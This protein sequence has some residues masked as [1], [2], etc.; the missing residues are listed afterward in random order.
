MVFSR[1]SK[2]NTGKSKRVKNLVKWVIVVR[3]LHTNKSFFE[4]ERKPKE[5]KMCAAAIDVGA[6]GRRFKFQREEYRILRTNVLDGPQSCR[7]KSQI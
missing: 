1:V 4:K 5:D 6:P 3:M 2:H 7:F